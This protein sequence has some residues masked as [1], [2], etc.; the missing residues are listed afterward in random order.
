MKEVLG[1]QV[2]CL[3]DQEVRITASGWFG[4]RV[5]RIKITSLGIAPDMPIVHLSHH[6]PAAQF[7]LSDLSVHITDPCLGNNSP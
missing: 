3:V 5:M 1:L 2:V 7:I 6:D 4:G